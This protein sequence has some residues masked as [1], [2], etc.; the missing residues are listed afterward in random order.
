MGYIASQSLIAAQLVAV[1]GFTF[2]RSAPFRGSSSLRTSSMVRSTAP[3][4]T[5]LLAHCALGD[6]RALAEL[7]R[8][9]R[10]RLYAVALRML[11]STD[12]AEEALQE[13]FVKIWKNARVYRPDLAAPMTWMTT[14]VRNQG[15]DMLRRR[16]PEQTQRVLLDE[17]DDRLEQVADESPDPLALAM[18]GEA[19]ASLSRCFGGLKEQQRQ[20]ISRAFYEGLSHAEL[21]D[22]TGMPLGSIKTS[23]RR[24]LLALRTC[25]EGLGAEAGR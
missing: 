3:D 18:Q 8:Q 10:S 11:R 23:I 19:A 15:L 14:I 7:Y 1:S 2:D 4:L 13:S 6:Q 20:L 25:L 16:Q 5:D 24:G 17:E 9:T 12:A 22:A 21:A